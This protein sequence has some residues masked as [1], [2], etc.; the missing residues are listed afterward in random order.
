VG[1]GGNKPPKKLLKKIKKK[2]KKNKNNQ[3]KNMFLTLYAHT[4]TKYETIG[5]SE[6]CRDKD[7]IFGVKR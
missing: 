6:I 7:A 1:G 4:W 2:K 3:Q 5:S